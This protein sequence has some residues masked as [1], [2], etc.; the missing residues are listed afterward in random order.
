[1]A[2]AT[3]VA[4]ENKRTSRHD[5]RERDG[6]RRWA[7]WRGRGFRTPSG[8]M[9]GP[10]PRHPNVTPS[11]LPLLPLPLGTFLQKP[12][13]LNRKF[14]EVSSFRNLRIDRNLLPN[15]TFTFIIL[16]LPSRTTSASASRNGNTALGNCKGEGHICA[17]CGGQQRQETRVRQLRPRASAMETIFPPSLGLHR[18]GPATSRVLFTLLVQLLPRR[19]PPTLGCLFVSHF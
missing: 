17:P 3:R 11:P 5:R 6:E 7:L 16:V 19:S 10:M 9:H 18:N 12:L 4:C 2:P 14:R 15:H 8:A 1:M 13:P